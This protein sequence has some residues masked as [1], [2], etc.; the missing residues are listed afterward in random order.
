[1]VTTDFKIEWSAY[2]RQA[3]SPKHLSRSDAQ[4]KDYLGQ[5]CNHRPSSLYQINE[6][7]MTHK[8]QKTR[9]ASLFFGAEKNY[10]KWEPRMTKLQLTKKNVTGKKILKRQ[11]AERKIQTIHEDEEGTTLFGKTT[12]SDDFIC[13]ERAASRERTTHYPRTATK[14]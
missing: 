9:R 3:V 10:K 4:R 11:H 6:H 1:M 5:I 13:L 14:P 12:R 8:W 7:Q 2:C